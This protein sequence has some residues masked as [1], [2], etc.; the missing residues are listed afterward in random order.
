MENQGKTQKQIKDS[1]DFASIGIVGT[2][3]L[4]LTA[5]ACELLF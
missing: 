1:Y 2:L 3:I 5:I 4:L